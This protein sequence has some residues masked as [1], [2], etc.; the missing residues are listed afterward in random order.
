MKMIV[1]SQNTLFKLLIF[2]FVSSLFSSQSFH[3]FDKQDQLREG[4]RAYDPK[5]CVQKT[6]PTSQA[7][8]N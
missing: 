4:K 2:F 6:T 8:P 5:K 7:T 1:L 3:S